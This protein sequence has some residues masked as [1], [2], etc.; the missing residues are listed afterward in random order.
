MEV[1]E[2]ASVPMVVDGETGVPVEVLV[3]IASI[4]L[5]KPAA[6]VATASVWTKLI[7]TVGV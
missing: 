4:V 7:L 3:G 1:G 2:L 6:K 5:V